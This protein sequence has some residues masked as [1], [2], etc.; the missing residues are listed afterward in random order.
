M[1]VLVA[2]A[3][4]YGSTKGIADFIARTLQQMGVEADSL[5]VSAVADPGQY[6]AFIIGSAVYMLHWL[7]Q[8]RDFV[9]RNRELL[10]SRP[11]WLFSSGPLGSETRN[12]QG[13]DLHDISG[14][15]EIGALR[16][17]VNPRCHRVFFGALDSRR[18]GLGHRLIRKMPAA[19][20]SLAEGDFRDW[21][22]IESWARGIGQELKPVLVS[23]P[24]T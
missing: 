18:L 10:S 6:D 21:K 9:A 17:A 22:E 7:G 19:R 24:A 8:A 14:P 16:E 15:S 4:K 1:K 12:T 2:Y 20:E 13:R 23:R 3:T 5:E 11:V